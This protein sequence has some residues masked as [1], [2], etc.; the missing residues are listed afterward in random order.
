VLQTSLL[1]DPVD[2]ER[3]ACAE[4]CAQ[5]CEFARGR[6]VGDRLAW[7][8]VIHGLW[9][10]EKL[11]IRARGGD[12]LVVP[13]SRLPVLRHPHDREI[14]RLAVPAFGALVA[15]PLFLLADAA[16]V[17]HLGTPQLAGLGV[18]GSLLATAVSLCIFLAYGTTAGVA[19][20]LGA[21]DRRAAI[22]L[23]VDGMWLATGLGI[24]IALAGFLAAEPLIEAFGTPASATP[25]ALTYLRV[26]L[27]GIPAMLVVMAAT[28][29]LRGLQDTRTPLVVAVVGA[30]ANVALNLALVYGAGMGIAGSALG[31]VL[32]QAGMAAA[33]VVVVV[34]GA[35]RHNAPLRPDLPGIRSAASTGVPLLLRTLT[36]RMALLVM[37]YV[38]T[39]QGTSA[40]AAHQVA[41]TIWTFLALALDAVAIAGQAIVGRYLGA[42]DADGTRAATRRI[43][44]WG[45]VAGVLTGLLVVALRFAYV[46]LFTDDVTVQALLG[47]VLVVAAVFQP[48]AGAVFALDWGLIGAG[49]G[50][51]LAWAGV[52]T[53][54]AFLPLAFWV[55]AVDAGLVALWWAF[56]AF[57]VARLVTLLLRERGTTWLVTGAELPHRR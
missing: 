25:Y 21:G 11:R 26:S 55:L 45:V 54:L 40:V 15:E 57:M 41:F 38:A 1:T 30:A 12:A 2:R 28:G 22:A 51:Y 32:A 5:P 48:V 36:L 39:A 20:R 23:G 9:R 46:P 34:R 49:D 50:R 6:P 17:G 47:S 7:D 43:V 56:G 29:V 42:G 44:E 31:T 18:A 13:S 8:D 14:V 4:R 16:I 10:K 33:F 27:L 35:L 3:G 19:R 24:A 37:A 53:L 52:I